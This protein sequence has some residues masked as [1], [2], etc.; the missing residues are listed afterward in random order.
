MFQLIYVL[1]F[2]SFTVKAALSV[3]YGPYCSPFNSE[4]VRQ[5]SWLAL[6]GILMEVLVLLLFITVFYANKWMEKK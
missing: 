3:E 4:N 2:G 6:T 5:M 1:V